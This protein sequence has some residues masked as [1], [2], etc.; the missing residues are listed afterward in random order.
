[1]RHEHDR[2][3]LDLDGIA[4]AFEQGGV[5]LILC[6]PYNPVGRLFSS[7]EL[8]ALAEVV[9]THDGRVVSDEIHAPLTYIGPHIPY[10]SVSDTAAGHSLTITS[11]SKAWNLPGLKCAAAITTNEAD[12][13]VWSQISMMRTHGASTIGIEANRAAFA[14][15]GPWL[16]S[17]VDYLD[18]TRTWFADVLAEHLPQVRYTPP[19]ATYFAWLDC[20]R[21]DLPAEPSQ[22]FLERARVAVNPGSA[23]GVPGEG[24]VRLNLATSRA[25]LTRIV[26]AMG[27]AVVERSRR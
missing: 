2:Y 6:Q 9:Q 22:F 10:A 25:M 5:T 15:G 24:F 19:E 12:E 18:G 21:L 23:F 16:E 1:M 27:S 14:S 26:T 7:E 4:A 11:A 13:R 3:A 17:A 8:A 20:R